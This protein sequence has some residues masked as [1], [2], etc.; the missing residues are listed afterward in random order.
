MKNI[1]MFWLALMPACSAITE[2]MTI[3]ECRFTLISVSA[4]DFTFSD[5]K[6]DFELKVQNP[7]KT[8]ATLDKLDYTFYVNQ[9]AV[10]S[11][12]TGQGLK[13]PAGKSANFTTTITLEYTKIGQALVEAIR[14]KTASYQIKARA[15]IKTMLGE[16][17]YPVEI[18]L[19]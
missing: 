2:R 18:N 9:T 1:T 11:G 19:K 16:I 14:F 4:Y 12:T 5:M 17:S 3:R 15:Y 10:F 13:I 8:N 7:N 6:V